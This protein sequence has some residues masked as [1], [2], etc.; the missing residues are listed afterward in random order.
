MKKKS[1]YALITGA[2]MGLGKSFAIDLAR[3]GKN[4]LLVAKKNEHLPQLCKYIQNTYKV[5]AHCF[6]TDLINLQSLQAMTIWANN[7]YA[8]DVL[9]NNVG[10]GGTVKF[11]SVNPSYVNNIIQ[12]NI[13]AFS[14]ITHQL[15]PN[16]IKT[17][18][19]AYIL[20][21]S[22]M[23]AFCPMGY[24]S[25]Y[26]ASKKFIHHFSQGLNYELKESNVSVATVFPGPM[27]TNENVSKRIEKQGFLVKTCLQTPDSVANISLN[28]LFDGKTFIIV[29]ILNKIN[30]FLLKLIPSDLIVPI[31]TATIKKE[32]TTK[33]LS[34]GTI[35]S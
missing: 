7:G 14:Y 11:E 28:K 2:S 21:V 16:L 24:K 20:N 3:R 17:D 8:I 32:L 19:N 25:V 10:I 34:Y 13:R 1:T 29:G 22:S 23:A 35:T 33:N 18:H 30:W 26:P 31:L 6:E 9:I 27:K 4:L 15:L 5:K 12:L